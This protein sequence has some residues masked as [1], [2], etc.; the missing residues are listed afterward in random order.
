MLAKTQQADERPDLRPVCRSH[1]ELHRPL[2]ECRQPLSPKSLTPLVIPT[3]NAAAPRLTRQQSL[4]RLRSNCTPTPG[5]APSR[6]GRTEDSPRT[7]TPFTPLSASLA[8]PR[9]AATTIL[10]ASTL[11]TP[12]SAPAE[13]RASPRPWEKPSTVAAVSASEGTTPEPSVTPKAEISDPMQSVVF[14]HR[15]HQSESGSIMERGRPR[16]R[17]ESTGAATLKRTGS[18]SSK[19]SERL[20]FEQLPRGWKASDAVNMLS[21]PEVASLQKQALQQAARFEVLRK[22]DVESLSRVCTVSACVFIDPIPLT[23]HS[24][25]SSTRRTY[26]VPPPH[27]H[28]PPSR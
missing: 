12:L 4:S 17:S 14:G 18:K 24:G 5:E 15:R 2:N 28:V 1:E 20:A 22:E 13:H 25:A 3:S 19:S 7:R 26:R 16:K 6:M 11:P 23:H 27:V 8:T 9:S 10:T 21:P